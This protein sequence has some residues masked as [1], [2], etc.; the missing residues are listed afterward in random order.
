MGKP[1]S[2]SHFNDKR[3]ND[4]FYQRGKV[5]DN[6]D[7]DPSRKHMVLGSK[8]NS[9]QRINRTGAVASFNEKD[10]DIDEDEEFDDDEEEIDDDEET[11]DDDDDDDDDDEEINEKEFDAT[12]SSDVETTDDDDE[13]DDKQKNFGT[14]S[15]EISGS[16]A[17]QHPQRGAINPSSTDPDPSSEENVA[18]GLELR[19]GKHPWK[20]WNA[21]F[22]MLKQNNY[23]KDVPNLESILEGEGYLH[24]QNSTHMRRAILEFSRERDDIIR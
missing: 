1:S 8:N 21:F 12:L 7:V 23:F 3:N 5:C 9:N 24:F 13:F 20:V 11:D 4:K 19:T 6:G 22:D 2:G 14:K 16:N 18:S 17:S 15:N 10:D